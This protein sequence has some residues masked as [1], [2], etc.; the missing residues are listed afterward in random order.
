M[1]LEKMKGFAKIM[2]VS[3]KLTITNM[4]SRFFAIFKTLFANFESH[5]II[6]YGVFFKSYKRNSTIHSPQIKKSSLFTDETAEN[7]RKGKTPR[8]LLC[9]RTVPWH[10]F[11][12]QALGSAA[13]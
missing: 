6:I 13:P 5:A 10:N 7:C 8:Y 9:Q 2:K 3:N 1:S 12:F 4:L 11:K